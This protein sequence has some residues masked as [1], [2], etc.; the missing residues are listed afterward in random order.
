LAYY[1]DPESYKSLENLA[2]DYAV[3]AVEADK[4]G[5]RSLA[6]SNYQKAVEYLIKFIELYP[7]SPLKQAYL[8]K[9]RE[10]RYRIAYLRGM[11][12][13]DAGEARIYA[14]DV[15]DVGSSNDGSDTHTSTSRRSVLGVSPYKSMIT[16]EDVVGL[17]EVKKALRQAIV[18]PTKRPDLFPLGWPRG[19]LLYG[20]PGCGK[21]TLA[22]AISNEIEGY[23]Y[24]IDASMIM[25]KWLG[26]GEKN[27][28]ALFRDLREIARSRTPVIL[29]IDEVDSILGIRVQE[30]G[31]E[32]R[33]RNQFLK[34]MDG[35]QDK[36][37]YK[38]PLFVIASTNK[39]WA[40]DWGF[41][42]RF[43]R[44][45][46]VPMPDM[47]TR[48][49]LFE[50]YLRDVRKDSIDYNY[51]AR[52]SNGYTPSDI[53]DICQLAVLEAV[54]ELFESGKAINPDSKPRPLNTKDIEEAIHRIK[55]SITP[56]IEAVYVKWADKFRAF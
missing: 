6:I 13:G 27:V 45:I 10:Y 29:F 38:L 20:P 52:I 50:Y 19:I 32:V 11:V 22:A 4:R 26:E 1:G 25:S 56:E 2:L 42:R 15:D 43:Q 47:E 41:I 16:W 51:L 31:G 39:P 21:T 37:N 36:D 40:L 8:K 17:D 9:V 34:E 35:L 44:R 3:K 24:P 5:L 7:D 55:P 53:R 18:Y 33:I 23:F 46:F 12:S 28:A 48:A 54:S 14:S 49:A 30:V